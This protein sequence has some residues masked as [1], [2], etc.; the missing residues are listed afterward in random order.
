[1]RLCA[2]IKKAEKILK[3]KPKYQK[4]KGL[5]DGLIKTINWFKNKENLKHYKTDIYNY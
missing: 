2:S 4:L 5:E 1:M 3:W